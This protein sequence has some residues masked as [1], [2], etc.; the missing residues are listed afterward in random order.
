M[1]TTFHLANTFAVVVFSVI[2]ILLM[3]LYFKKSSRQTTLNTVVN[4]LYRQCAR[5]AVASE[6]DE[7]EIIR[8]LHANYATGYLWALKDIVS[9][10]VFK[11][12]T[13]EDFLEFEKRIVEIQDKATAKLV[14]KCKSVIPIQ[15]PT[16]LKAMYTTP[17]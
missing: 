13:G 11:K 14:H 1:R 5:W 8:V 17:V 15:D 4:I 9:T 7:S 10:D 6:Q 12:I 2:V 3:V 16:L